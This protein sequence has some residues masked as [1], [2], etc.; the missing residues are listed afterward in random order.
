MNVR[1]LCLGI[2]HFGEVTGYEIKKLAEDGKFCYFI[3][4]SFGAIYPA[5]T[6]MFNEGLV[7]WRAEVQEGKPSRKVYSITDLGRSTFV[8][9]LYEEPKPDKFKSE[10]LLMMLCSNILDADYVT[11]LIDKKITEVKKELDNL[12]LNRAQQASPS[13]KF[14]FGYGIH[15]NKASLEFL[16]NQRHIIENQ[17]FLPRKK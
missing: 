13:E 10:F 4:A 7:T 17:E 6:R 5:L 16:Y 8:E 11:K 3:E 12:E 14:V 15:M 1:T 2:L 9:Q